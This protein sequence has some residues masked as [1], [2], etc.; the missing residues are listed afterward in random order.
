M[1]GPQYFD[2]VMTRRT[3]RTKSKSNKNTI[4]TVHGKSRSRWNLFY[5]LENECTSIM[6]FQKCRFWK[7][8]WFSF[9]F[10]R[11]VK[12]IWIQNIQGQFLKAT[13]NCLPSE[14][15]KKYT[16]EDF[17]TLPV[18]T[19]SNKGI[20]HLHFLIATLKM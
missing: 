17:K 2:K 14:F 18:A 19:W 20:I 5:I 11:K 15:A 10:L 12:Q 1:P 3:Q 13:L 9:L 6:Q 4:S 7:P 16:E 8:G